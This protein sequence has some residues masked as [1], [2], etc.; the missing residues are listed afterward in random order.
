MGGYEGKYHT[1]C[2]SKENDVGLHEPL[3][4]VA[5]RHLFFLDQLSNLGGIER[6]LAINTALGCEASMRF[7][8]L[9]LRNTC[10]SLEG[11]DVLRE[12]GPQK[13]FRLQQ[14]YE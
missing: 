5:F 6:R 7:H 13:V 12:T 11:I 8:Q 2:L 10:P 4:P 9:L 3:A 14:T 1:H